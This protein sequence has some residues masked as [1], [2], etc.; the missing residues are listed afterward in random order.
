[1]ENTERV[2]LS[3]QLICMLPPLALKILA[4]MLNWQKFDVIKYYPRQ[5]EKFMHIDRTAL[6]FG[7]QTLIDNH[8]LN[9][10]KVGE[11]YEFTINK[12]TVKKYFT[13]PMDKICS[14]DGIEISQKVTWN[15]ET[16]P[17]DSFS[18]IS[19]DQLEKMI[20]ELQRRR[21]EK[22]KDCQVIYAKDSGFEIDSLPF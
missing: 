17:K 21:E 13:V 19:D 11:D 2:Y 9:V 16:T 12:E 4:Y 18:N 14:H 10:T 8:L 3:Q 6:E 20:M 15:K 22:K 5:M 7:I 1:M